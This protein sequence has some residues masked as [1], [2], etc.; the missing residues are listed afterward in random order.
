MLRKLAVWMVLLGLLLT[1]P[2]TLHAQT[3]ESTPELVPGCAAPGI[4]YMM[5]QVIPRVL[6][7]DGQDRDYLVYVSTRYDPT[8]P[9]PLVFNLHGFASNPQQEMDASRMNIPAEIENFIAVYP[10]GT[11]FPLRWSAYLTGRF[12]S[13]ND[14][15]VDDVGFISAL[16]DSLESEYCIDPARIYVTGLSNGGGMTHRLACELAD[17]IAAIGTVAGAYPPLD[18]ACNPSRP[19]PVIAFHGDADPIVPYLGS[20]SDFPPIQDWAAAWAARNGCDADP[21]VLPPSGSVTG[22]HYGSCDANADVILYTVGGGGHTW[23][24]G[25]PFPEFIAGPTSED[26]DATRVMWDFFTAHPME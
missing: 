6:Q 5:G 19:V 15:P 4:R 7:I 20:E 25:N 16:I 1:L 8:Q 18:M 12:A 3:A 14:H 9:T 17:R 26:I 11:G 13:M 23:P 24:G 21:E 10:Q 22:I 2:L